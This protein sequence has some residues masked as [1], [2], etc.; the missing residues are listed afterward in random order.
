MQKQCYNVSVSRG[1]TTPSYCVRVRITLQGQE[2]GT[3]RLKC[4][5]TCRNQIS[6]FGET[7]ESI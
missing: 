4:D 2:N 5:D 1:H 6:S 7:D 3:V